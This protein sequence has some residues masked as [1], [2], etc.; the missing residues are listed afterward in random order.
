M[1]ETC[2]SHPVM[3]ACLN[4]FMVPCHDQKTKN[5]SVT[6]TSVISEHRGGPSLQEYVGFPQTGLHRVNPMKG[7]NEHFLSNII[8]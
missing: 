8:C 1:W 7:F 6:F 5:T 2:S 4:S 3:I